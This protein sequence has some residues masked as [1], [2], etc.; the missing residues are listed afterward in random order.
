MDCNRK[1]ILIDGHSLAYRAFFALPD[2]LTTSGGQQTNAVYGFLSMLLK[3]IEEVRPDAVVVALDGPRRELKRVEEYPEYKAN[4]P[5]TPEGF[6]VQMEMVKE[7]LEKMRIPALRVPGVEADDILGTVAAR[8]ARQGD[9]AVIVTGDRDTLQLVED[10]VTVMM[11]GKGITETISYDTRAVIEKLGI[12][13]E[14]IPDYL[15]LKGDSSDNIPG[16]PGIGE[17][18]ASSLIKEF[19]SLEGLYE[20]LEKIPGKRKTVL[21]DNREIAFLSKK[22]ATIECDL[23]IEL[24][25][26][27]LKLGDWELSEVLAYMDELEFKTLSRRFREIFSGEL[28]EKTASEPEVGINCRVVRSGDN[29]DVDNFMKEIER[30]GNVA[31]SG[32]LV[33]SG[34]CDVELQAIALAGAERILIV[35]RSGFDG[36]PAMKATVRIL[37]SPEIE[38]WFHDAK[39]FIQALE[40]S[41]INAKSISFDTAIAAY[42]DNPSQGSYDIWDVWEKSVGKEIFIDEKPVVEEEQAEL[43]LWSEDLSSEKLGVQAARILHLKPVLESKITDHGMGDLFHGLE[44]PLMKVLSDME[45]SG[46]TV[47]RDAL[48]MMSESAEG[49]IFLLEREIFEMAGREFNIGS[50]KQLAAVLFDEMG[51]T[52]IK[53]TK[54]GYST[55]SSVLEV[56]RKD[57]EI[58]AKVLDYRTF[59]KLKSTYLD[60]LPGLICPQTGKIHCQFNQTVTATGRI[61]SSNPNLQNI[62]IRSEFGKEIRTAFIP[63]KQGWK[64]LVADYSQIE[65]R[66]LAHM[67]EDAVMIEA[68]RGGADIHNETASLVFGVDP[69]AVTSDQRRIAKM[70]NFGVVY[71]MSYYGLSTRLGIPLEEATFFINAYF[72][73]FS[74]AKEFQEKCVKE[75][76]KRGYVETMMGRRRYIPEVKSGNRQ[77]REFGER[78]AVNTP[79]QGSAADI[80]KKAMVDIRCETEERGL[81]SRMT[82][83]VHD[84]LIFDVAPDEVDRMKGLV[85][86]LM[87]GAAELLVPLTVDIG[88]CNNWGEAK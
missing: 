60:A 71:G 38:K 29:E 76:V 34:Y 17:K 44:M 32:A 25:M 16:V 23:D 14:N 43:S 59:T 37:E 70:V 19:G 64:M 73:R 27:E 13:P 20:N 58:A 72:E 33:G 85:S 22:L 1:I 8:V 63:G 69:Q 30:E 42:L 28:G 21:E 86:R 56:L 15:G 12:Q 41:G 81:K 3:V 83:Q 2:T 61:S 31:V 82:L 80:I 5:P 77:V 51:I 50:P 52:P 49:K 6:T 62:P 48:G 46:V 87:T 88:V 54:T 45:E 65:L 11:T 4:R 24:D 9:E 57:H 55:D 74:G 79:I 26:R 84:E 47:D 78:M 39:T 66:V 68:F 67:S 18:G 75:A 7:L 40:K 35:E 36:T 53:K 10:R